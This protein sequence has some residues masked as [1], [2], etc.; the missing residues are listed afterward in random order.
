MKNHYIQAVLEMIDSGSDIQS[1]LKGLSVSLEKKGHTRL[2]AAVLRGVVRILSS[3]ITST[4]AIV[5]IADK[6]L[7]KG[8]KE[9]ITSALSTL[10]AGK[11]Y[12]TIIDPTIIGGVIVEYN[13]TIIDTSYKTQ[14]VKLYRTLTK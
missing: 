1:V 14:L 12:Q 10:S 4:G 3:K 8:H 7:L 6:D 9:A 11:D 13:N 5:T 2:H